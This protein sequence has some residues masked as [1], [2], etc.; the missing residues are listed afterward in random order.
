MLTIT[1]IEGQGDTIYFDCPGCGTEI[2]C[3]LGLDI[4]PVIC[5]ECRVLLPDID[6]IAAQRKDR[7]VY[8]LD[9]EI[10]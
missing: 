1:E 6:L 7:V 2:A 8:H 10:F 5:E 9:K 4:I 3:Q